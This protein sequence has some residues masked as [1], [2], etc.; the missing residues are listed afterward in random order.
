MVVG[1]TAG[2]VKAPGLVGALRGHHLDVLIGNESAARAALALDAVI[3]TTTTASIP[4]STR[5]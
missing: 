1:V 4:S 3:P 5:V 2:R